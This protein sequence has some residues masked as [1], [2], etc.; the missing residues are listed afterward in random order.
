MR[1]E[2]PQPSGLIRDE[3][4]A[5]VRDEGKVDGVIQRKIWKQPLDGVGRGKIGRSDHAVG[6]PRDSRSSRVSAWPPTPQAQHQAEG[7]TEEIPS[8]A[9][10]SALSCGFAIGTPAL[11][12]LHE[13]NGYTGLNRT[14]E[15]KD[16]VMGRE[17]EGAGAELE[18]ELAR[19]DG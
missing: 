15:S 3:E 18:V 9:S 4:A 17:P 19:Q 11:D 2:G 1:V 7:S 16:N 13:L 8:L 6:I 14:Q 12:C 5:S 10:E